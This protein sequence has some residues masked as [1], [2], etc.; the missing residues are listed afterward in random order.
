[1]YFLL[2]NK[3]NKRIKIKFNYNL[4]TTQKSPK[5]EKKINNA[6]AR[7]IRLPLAPEGSFLAPKYQGKAS[8][9]P[10]IIIIC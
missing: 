1:M 6:P 8:L 5:S 7:H 3:R 2:N 4:P 10:K 9:F